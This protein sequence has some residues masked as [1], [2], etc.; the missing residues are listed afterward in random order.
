MGKSKKEDSFFDNLMA[1]PSFDFGE[2]LALPKIVDISKIKIPTEAEKHFY[3]SSGALIKHLAERIEFWKKSIQENSQPVILVI[4]SNG[5]KIR[6]ENLTQQGHNG[7]IIEGTIEEHHCMI[8]AH[9]ATLQI[10]CYIEKI[11]DKKQRKNPI[12]F[13]YQYEK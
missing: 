13:H 7:I 5:V 11:K 9:Q 3:E 1:L 10:L 4:L 2:T 12:G 6:A 8:L